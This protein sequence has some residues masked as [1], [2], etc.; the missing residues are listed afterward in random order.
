MSS[1]L[2]VPIPEIPIPDLAEPNA[3]PTQE[4]IMDAAHPAN[5]KKGAKSGVSSLDELMTTSWF[6]MSE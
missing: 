6:S 3:A 1:G 4:K 5:P 2:K